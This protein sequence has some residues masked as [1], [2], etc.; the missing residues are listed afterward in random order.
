MKTYSM[1]QLIKKGSLVGTTKTIFR[2][3]GDPNAPDISSVA[4]PGSVGFQL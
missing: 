4:M 1:P 3:K 2:F